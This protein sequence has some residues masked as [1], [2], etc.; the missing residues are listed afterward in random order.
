[1]K[2]YLALILLSVVACRSTYYAVWEKLGREKRD[3]LRHRVVDA[4]D[5][6]E[7]ARGHLRGSVN[8]G[9]GGR[10]AEY[11][12]EV[13]EPGTAIVLVTPEGDLLVSDDQAGAIYR[14]RYTGR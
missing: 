7:F 2:R 5:D 12:G 10:F 6:R 11:V 14:I 4:R 13:M 1:M 8:V 9:L 3:I